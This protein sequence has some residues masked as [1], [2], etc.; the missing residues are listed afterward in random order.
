MVLFMSLNG[1]TVKGNV[2]EVYVRVV[3]VVT[4]KVPKDL[5]EEVDKAVSKY[6]F[7]NRSEFIKKAIEEY[8]K[9]LEGTFP[10]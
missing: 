7:Y 1:I 10:P 3:K 8:I 9:H 4:F 6:G 2:L 5:Y